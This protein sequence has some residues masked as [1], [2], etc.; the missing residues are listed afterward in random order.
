MSRIPLISGRAIYLAGLFLLAAVYYPLKRNAGVLTF[1]A[2]CT[3]YLFALSVIA[4]V[5]QKRRDRE[6]KQ[7]Q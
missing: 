1:L 5:M 4:S 2:A 7:R 3:A 6:L